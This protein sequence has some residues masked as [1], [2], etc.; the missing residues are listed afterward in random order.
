MSINNLAKSTRQRHICGKIPRDTELYL[1]LG[2]NIK[3]LLRGKWT[4]LRSSLSKTGNPPHSTPALHSITLSKLPAHHQ[5][6]PETQASLPRIFSSAAGVMKKLLN[7]VSGGKASV[8]T[9]PSVAIKGPF[10]CELRHGR[11]V[12]ICD[13]YSGIPLDPSSWSPLKKS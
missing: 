3:F 1:Y 6:R 7:Y 9:K 11:T 2:L 4:F 13:C 10:L 5:T 12:I 8:N